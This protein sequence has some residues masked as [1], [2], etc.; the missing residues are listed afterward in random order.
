M[1]ET[2]TFILKFVVLPIVLAASAV[3]FAMIAALL[4]II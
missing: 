1:K 4:A 3:F 2:F